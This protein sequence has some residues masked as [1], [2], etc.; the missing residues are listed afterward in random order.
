MNNVGQIRDAN[1]RLDDGRAWDCVH[2]AAKLAKVTRPPAS[3]MAALVE[4][5]RVEVAAGYAE[6]D[7]CVCERDRDRQRQSER[8]GE[9]MWVVSGQ[10]VIQIKK[11]R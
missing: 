2:L 10:N 9:C 11:G 3:N 4:G 8:E 1:A 5:Q 6:M 7:G